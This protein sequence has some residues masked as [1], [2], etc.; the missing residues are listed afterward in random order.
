MIY[1]YIYI[2]NHPIGIYHYW[3]GMENFTTWILLIFCICGWFVC[4]FHHAGPTNRCCYE[5][6]TYIPTIDPLENG[7]LVHLPTWMV[8]L[9]MVSLCPYSYTWSICARVDQL[10]MSGMVIP[11][12]MANPYDRYIKPYYWVDDHPVLYGNNVSWILPQMFFIHSMKSTNISKTMLL[13]F[14][15]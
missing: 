14:G 15:W 2:Y 11:P 1:I 5:N 12:V 9:Y 3:V 13:P 7:T 6:V 4:F 10:L 8:D